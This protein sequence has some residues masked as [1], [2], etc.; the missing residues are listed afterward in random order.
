MAKDKNT[1]KSLNKQN[2]AF[3]SFFKNFAKEEDL[4]DVK[5]ASEMINTKLDVISTGSEA[6][7]DALGCGGIPL[8]RIVQYYGPASSGK[9]LMTL[10]L[11][12]EAQKKDPTATQLFIDAEQT[13]SPQWAQSLGLDIS[14][15]HVIDGHTAS[16]GRDLFT[17]L[18]GTPKEDSKKAYAGKKEEGLLD[19]IK[20]KELNINVI[21]LDSLGGLI[22]PQ[23]DT[24]DIGKSNMAL[25][26]RFLPPTLRKLCVEVS[27][28]NVAFIIINH[29]KASMSMYGSDH[30]YSGGNA[31]THSLSANIYF[32]AVQRKDAQIL[33]DKEQKIGQTVRS[34]IEKSKFGSN[35]KC[36]FKVSFSEGVIDSHEEIANLAIKYDLIE[37]PNG[38]MYLYTDNNSEN[39]KWRGEGAFK[40]AL[41]ENP[42]LCEELKNKIKS[43]RENKKSGARDIY[44]VKGADDEV[45]SLELMEEDE[46]SSFTDADTNKVSKRGKKAKVVE[47]EEE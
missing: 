7:N 43:A 19:K 31:Y 35:S 21:V 16:Y 18:L 45:D 23:E 13:F 27:K 39:Y 37:Q 25:M 2:E 20:N 12:K 1:D 28:A 33:D 3:K 46:N 11:I 44:K 22:P 4:G 5:S 38:V 24:S 36:E 10:L 15:I 41:A 47:T 8:G 26:A 34:A 40:A 42:E 30:T 9:T 17:M 32:E 6:L 14:R 29:V